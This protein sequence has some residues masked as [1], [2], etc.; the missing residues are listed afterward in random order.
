MKIS[1][2]LTP[3]ARENAV[4][5]VI[6]L[7]WNEIYLVRVKARPVA[8]E[9]NTMLI[10]VLAKYFWVAKRFVVLIKGL[11]SRNKIVDIVT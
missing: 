9:A 4:E 10:E 5:K 3:W 6:D 2:R 7:L 8:W 11:K 1:V